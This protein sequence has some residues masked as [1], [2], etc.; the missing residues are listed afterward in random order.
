MSIYRAP[1]IKSTYFAGY[2]LVLFNAFVRTTAFTLYYPKYVSIVIRL[3]GYSFL[4]M[5]VIPKM[6][7][8]VSIRCLLVAAV[9]LML[10]LFS[11]IFSG[12]SVSLDYAICCTFAIGIDFEEIT[13]LYVWESVI[14]TGV[15]IV[16]ALLG[17]II[18][19]IYY[20]SGTSAVRMSMGFVYPTDFAAHVF[21]VMAGIIF[22]IYDRF[23]LKD[24]FIFGTVAFGCFMLTNARGPCAMVFFLALL[25][26]FFRRFWK[27][28]I[29]II[30]VWLLKYSTSICA[31]ITLFVIRV[32][33]P[34]IPLWKTIDSFTSTRLTYAKDIFTR[35]H[36][37]LFGQ[38]IAQKGNGLGG[39][40]PG[41]A[42][43]YIDISYQR[44]LLMYG[45]LMFL[46]ILVFCILLNYKALKNNSMAIPLLIL[47]I[48]IYSM[49]AQHF[50]DFSYNFV[51][52]ALFAD[53]PSQNAHDLLLKRKLVR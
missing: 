40:A 19:Y 23:S 53:I 35:N 39:R 14:L 24:L 32:F 46:L 52:L 13:R 34:K 25:V 8:K 37:T 9:F 42:H 49:T 1:F 17:G 5:S 12:Y 28:G 48:S 47:V 20:R 44:I 4:I 3:V 21:F 26:W 31:L 43:T 38:Y 36:I 22:L 18:N 2:A 15:T 6:N 7:K 11:Y 50:F 51:L 33:N 16:S 45:L 41:E 27:K 10:S 30:P 29:Q